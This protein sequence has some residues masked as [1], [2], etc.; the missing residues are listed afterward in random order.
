MATAAGQATIRTANA[1]LA[2]LDM[3]PA[4]LL[5][6]KLVD[7]T[8]AYLLL[9]VGFYAIL[10]E[11]FHP[12]AIAPGATGAVC[13]ILAF[14][15][16]AALPLNWGGVLLILVAVALFVID[17]KATTHGVL[18][19]AGLACFIL[20]SLLLY[21]PPGARSPAL[22]TA[23]VAPVALIAI[24]VLGA[25]LATLVVGAAVRVARRPPISGADRLNG[26][27]GVTSTALE[28]QGVVSVGGQLWSARLRDGRLEPGQPV[29][30]L[31]REGLTLEVEP[32]APGNGNGEWPDDA[33]PAAPA[34][35]NGEWPDYKVKEPEP[36]QG[37]PL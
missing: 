5:F 14:V 4:E 3:N 35:G 6:Q 24:T 12:G 13:L 33:E 10:I 1:P 36:G 17:V 25:L 28:P 15:A 7:P 23:A 9:T 29:R 27:T 34:N 16:F 32:A 37:V 2:T 11:L 26:A 21:N 20:G 8:V 22:P 30:V 31:G 18:T 19:V